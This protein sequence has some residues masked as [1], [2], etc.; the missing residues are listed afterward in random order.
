MTFLKKINFTKN[1]QFELFS[2][3]AQKVNLF[4]IDELQS[5]KMGDLDFK[6]FSKKF[7]TILYKGEDWEN[8]IANPLKKLFYGSSHDIPDHF[9]SFRDLLI[10]NDEIGK[11]E[12]YSLRRALDSINRIIISDRAGT[13]E[14]RFDK[15]IVK[16]FV[17]DFHNLFG[18]RTDNLPK[19]RWKLLTTVLNNVEGFEEYKIDTIFEKEDIKKLIS[20]KSFQEIVIKLNVYF[21]EW[22]NFI[23][24]D[25]FKLK[26]IFETKKEEFYFVQSIK[27]GDLLVFDFEKE[28]N[29]FFLPNNII[30]NL[31]SEN[32]SEKEFEWVKLR[33]DN[34]NKALKGYLLDIDKLTL[35][36]Y[37]TN[38][39]PLFLI[40]DHAIQNELLFGDIGFS[41]LVQ[42]IKQVNEEDGK[43]IKEIAS[44]T[45]C[46]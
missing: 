44:K 41:D 10:E 35:F 34:W 40:S 13:F 12:L 42:L 29:S 36:D 21:E 24:S 46:S 2:I 33:I 39:V 17:I 38:K 3:I 6:S 27:P 22:D 8:Y 20:N 37:I 45:L 15:S 4:S 26:M 19:E 30:F 7:Y 11:T 43:R 5:L 28:F 23:S 32:S 1:Q 16:S 14:S 25:E 9:N 18:C 31:F